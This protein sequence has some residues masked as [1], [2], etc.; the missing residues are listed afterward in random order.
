MDNKIIQ[1]ISS[2]K[3]QKYDD[4]VYGV[5]NNVNESLSVKINDFFID[6]SRVTLKDK[7]Y[8]FH[9]LAVMLNAGIPLVKSLHSLSKRSENR[10]FARILNTIAYNTEQGL[11]LADSMQRFE[12]VFDEFEIGIV[13]SGES[14]GRLDE[15]L[16]KLSAKLDSKHELSEKLW[17]AAIYPIVVFAVLILV[18]SVM[19][20]WVFPTLLGLFEE[21]G[22][23]ASKLP[24]ATR[25]LVSLQDIIIN[26]W[27]AI[28][29][30]VVFVY[31]V[32]LSYVG[33]ESGRV[34][35]DIL[36]LKIPFYGSLL[37]KIYVLRFVDM[38]AIL[39]DAG[40][41][42]VK[43]LEIVQ[44]SMKNVAYRAVSEQIALGVKMGEK[45]SDLMQKFEFLFPLEVIEM[46]RTGE[47]SASLAKVSEKISVQYQKE[48]DFSLR[49]L[50]SIFEPAMIV[51]VGLFVAL[52]ALAIMGPIFNLSSTAL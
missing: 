13:K 27:W 34:S 20:F 5:Y 46:I 21:G 18:A 2:E 42:V 50:T 15:M 48:V 38:L 36:K 11:P 28:V 41:P 51:F 3:V 30:G 26:Y 31:T 52:L 35:F 40:V 37:K 12:N 44:N 14:I 22:L 25:L 16:F 17:G 29:A 6:H 4:V 47:S 9:M 23:G 39:I 33:T 32:F 19:M 10:R 49:K 45:I 43:V 1:R 7:S 8:F 24:F